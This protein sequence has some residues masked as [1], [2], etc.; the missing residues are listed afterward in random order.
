MSGNKHRPPADAREIVL[1]LV[2]DDG[3]TLGK[4]LFEQM[5]QLG[6]VPLAIAQ[7]VDRPPQGLLRAHPERVVEA[8][9]G[10]FDAKGVVENEQWLGNGIDDALGPNMRVAQE[11]VDVH[12]IH[13]PSRPLSH[14]SG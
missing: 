8:A 10:G 14:R 11:T 9:A 2:V 3:R 4:D 5:A 1:D 7:V 12:E 13:E 6:N